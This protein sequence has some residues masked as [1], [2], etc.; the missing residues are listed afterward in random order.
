MNENAEISC[1]HLGPVS[2]TKINATNCQERLSYFDW[3]NELL[4]TN[5]SSLRAF[6]NL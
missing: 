2:Q 1:K 4:T 6:D 5:H 3:S